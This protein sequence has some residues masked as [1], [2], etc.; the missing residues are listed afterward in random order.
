MKSGFAEIRAER[1]TECPIADG[2]LN[3]ENEH[4]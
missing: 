3:K 4:A 1:G 2:G